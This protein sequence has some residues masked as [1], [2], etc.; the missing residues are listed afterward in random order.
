MVTAWQ[1]PQD[2]DQ[3]PTLD[4]KLAD[5]IK[6]GYRI[7]TNTPAR[8]AAATGGSVACANCH[9]NAGQRERA[10]PLVGITGMFPEFNNRAARLISLQ[11]RVVD[12]FLR[13]ENATGA[14]HRRTL[15][16]TD[17]KEVLAVTAYLTWLG[18]GYAVGANPAWRNK[19]AIAA[20]QADPGR[21]SSTRRPARRSTPSA[22]RRATARD[23]QGVQIGD[24]KAGPL[25]G[26][27]SWND[28][29]GAAR[30]YTL[31]GIIRYSMPYLNPGSLTDEEAQQVARVHHLEAAAALSVQVARLRRRRRFRPTPSTTARSRLTHACA[32]SRSPSSSP[33]ALASSADAQFQQ[34]RGGG[35]FGRGMRRS[36]TRTTTARS[37]SAA[38]CSATPPTATAAAGRST[39]RARTMNLS[40]RLSE[41]TAHERQPRRRPANPNHV[42]IPLTD[43]DGSSQCPFIMMTEPGGT[44]FDEAEA[45]GLRE[46]LLKGGF[47]WAD[48]FWGDYAFEHWMNELRKALPSSEYPLID[49]PLDHPLF[50][51]LYD[52]KAIPQIPS[53]NFWYGTGGGTSERGADSADAARARHAR[54]DGRI[55]VLMTHNTDFGDAFEREGDNREYFERFAGAGYAFG[56][57]TL[58]YAMTH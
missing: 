2:P 24:K 42:V 25:W 29:A 10:L 27:G 37:C 33:A 28:G 50:H 53:I 8:S 51:V 55:M 6:W 1:I 19:N 49:V 58:L 17:S 26:D 20:G 46:Y 5:Q 9:L 41:L 57:N 7:F 47:L 40:F 21:P 48:D 13:S 12:C 54:R 16:T 52:V 32:A 15:P 39:G 23:G 31:A 56:I 45:A 44:Y 3:G 18:R 30:V 11:D 14:R 22:A 38:S 43:T 35:R 36:P 34:R 4:P